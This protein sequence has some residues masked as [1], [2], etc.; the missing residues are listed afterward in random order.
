M[1]GIEHARAHEK[2]RDHGLGRA[3][4]AVLDL[5]RDA[6]A[7][8]GDD[9]GEDALGAGLDHRA[10]GHRA[11]QTGAGAPLP[12][13]V[14]GMAHHR[15]GEAAHR[16][17]THAGVLRGGE[18]GECPRESF[19]RQREIRRRTPVDRVFVAV[20]AT[21]VLK[22][23]S[24]GPLHRMVD[25]EIFRPAAE[26]PGQREEPAMLAGAVVVPLIRRPVGPDHRVRRFLVRRHLRPAA[27][28]AFAQ[29]EFREPFLTMSVWIAAPRCEAQASARR[30]SDRPAASAAPLSTSGSAWIILTALRGRMR[31]PLSPQPATRPMSWCQIAT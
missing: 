29:P 7:L 30:T 11:H 8:F 10:P 1:I 5:D 16:L 9:R 27:Q 2:C 12:G 14:F 18:C 25:L 15:R 26:M 31:P 23:R 6:K 28:V 4:G 21:E 13:D 17:A 20:L 3:A 22:R 19:Q 24:H